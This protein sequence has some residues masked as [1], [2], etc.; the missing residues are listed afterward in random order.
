VTITLEPVW[1]G[2][3][4]ADW[5]TEYPPADW[6]AVGLDREALPPLPALNG[7]FAWLT[8]I[9]GEGMPPIEVIPVELEEFLREH[10]SR[11]PAAFRTF[12]DN[13]GLQRRIPVGSDEWAEELTPVASPAELGAFLIPLLEDAQ[14]AGFH[15]LYLDPDGSAPVVSL[16]EDWAPEDLEEIAED[17]ADDETTE[18]FLEAAVLAAPDFESFLYRY[19]IELRSLSEIQDDRAWEELSPQVQAYLRFYRG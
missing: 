17:G 12:L 6:T 4:V 1:V 7:D 19:W 2:P 16:P 9:D 15:Y 18:S 8:P 10:G 13:P 3:S 11:L 14:G 5:L